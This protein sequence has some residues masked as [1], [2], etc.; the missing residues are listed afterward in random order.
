MNSLQRCQ[1]VFCI[2]HDAHGTS[3]KDAELNAD[4]NNI[5]NVIF[6]CGSVEEE[7]TKIVDQY[8][9]FCTENNGMPVFLDASAT[10]PQHGKAFF[11]ISVLYLPNTIFWS[12]VQA[13]FRVLRNSPTVHRVIVM[14]RRTTVSSNEFIELCASAA[15]QSQNNVE[16]CPSFVPVSVL[17]FDLY[18]NVPD[19]FLVLKFVRR[20]VAT[21]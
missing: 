18:E 2:D 12:T 8:S 3:W 19:V 5:D 20:S 9:G 7:L 1:I 16:R 6:R 4:E 13:V 11:Y 17:A 10:H 21:E 14:F 15:D